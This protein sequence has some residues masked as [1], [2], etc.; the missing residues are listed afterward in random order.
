MKKENAS[1]Y[2][3]VALYLTLSTI[4]VSANK[5]ERPT[6]ERNGLFVH[7]EDVDNICKVAYH[8]CKANNRFS[9]LPT[10]P[11]L[12]HNNPIAVIS[13]K[14]DY[15]L[16]FDIVPTATVSGWG[17]I[18]HFTTGNDCCEHGSQSPAIWFIPGTTRL[19]IRIGDSANF[20]WP[21]AELPDALPLNVRTT[22]TLECKGKDVKLTVGDKVYTYTQPNQRFAGN[23]I[24]YA[25]DAKWDIAKATI[26]D[27]DYY[28]I[29]G[30]NAAQLLHEDGMNMNNEEEGM[31][32]DN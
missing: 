6:V 12:L 22:V 4:C 10:S 19:H 11:A 7:E 28:E 5:L 15:R 9:D 20:N 2:W 24:V 21:A 3:T 18:L 13:G 16:S 32:V 31:N 14:A 27:L 29:A 30:V 23:L 1:L 17:S 8:R 25:G 26:Y